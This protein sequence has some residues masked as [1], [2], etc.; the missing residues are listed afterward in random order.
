MFCHIHQTHC[1][2]RR[3]IRSDSWIYKQYHLASLA[4]YI[5]NTANEEHNRSC[6]FKALAHILQK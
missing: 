2:G 5:E 4:Y 3:T 1:I 6:I